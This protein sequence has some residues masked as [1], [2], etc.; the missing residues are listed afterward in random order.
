[1]LS[2]EENRLLNIEEMKQGNVALISR[3]RIA[4]I[5]LTLRCNMNCIMCFTQKMQKIDMADG[6]FRNA[7]QLFSTLEEARW[8]DAG[9]LFASHSC[10]EY[11]KII[12]GLRIPKSYLS[13]NLKD[14]DKYIDYLVGGGFT[15]LSVSIDAATGATYEAIRRGGK[16]DKLQ[17]NLDLLVSSKK[18]G[19]TEL[20][21]LT[22]VFIAMRR[23]MH[24][25]PAFVDLARR[26]EAREIHVLKLLPNPACL[27]LSETI[28]LEEL[29]PFYKE[30]FARAKEYGIRLSHIAYT[31]D[32][33]LQTD[34]K[35]ESEV[36]I[37]EDPALSSRESH[38]GFKGFPYCQSPWT[39]ILIDVEG[40][41]RPCCYNP[42][43]LGSLKEHS[44]LDIWNNEKYQDF[45]RKMLN[46]DFYECH[47]C[48]WQHK[49]FHYLSPE[50]KGT[51]APVNKRL[52]AMER[53][54]ELKKDIYHHPPFS[55]LKI[56]LDPLAFRMN[57]EWDGGILLPDPHQTIASAA[58]FDEQKKSLHH[59]LETI[60]NK[61][62]GPP[63]PDVSRKRPVK[64]FL[65]RVVYRLVRPIIEPE[66]QWHKD[67][68]IDS[69][70]RFEELSERDKNVVSYIDMIRTFLEN[71]KNFNA[72][73]VQY[74]NQFSERFF[75]RVER[76]KDLNMESLHAFRQTNERIDSLLRDNALLLQMMTHLD[77]KIT[78]PDNSGMP[79]PTRLD[80]IFYG[81]T[82]GI[83]G[84]DKEIPAASD[85]LL[86]LTVSNNSLKIWQ[87]NSV[88]AVGITVF[89]CDD[90]NFPLWTG[91]EKTTWLD[92]PLHPGETKKFD[93][94][95]SVPAKA[96]KYTLTA[97]LVA[98]NGD[99]FIDRGTGFEH[100]TFEVSAHDG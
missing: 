40:N 42:K 91:E 86:T 59:Q 35:A 24:E 15:H 14:A 36:V 64:N 11:L 21:Y 100:S 31:D 84:P 49:V 60:R 44:V 48:S 52:Q 71:Q 7:T 8:N 67:M 10:E 46:H 6:I 95:V 22:L 88:Y 26:Y 38:F 83:N 62:S 76:Q 51:F 87:P 29:R 68:A 4:S 20:P 13:T 78:G 43:V 1:M 90:R 16:F 93:I 94:T 17:K 73:L 81:A 66:F 72:L 27:E 53:A 79:F 39:E 37:E 28:E 77:E 55:D 5:G 18:R 96:G 70:Q 32:E 47:H 75:E 82:V 69:F 23:N 45:R 85:L 74:L 54:W 92:K 98:S 63:Q 65:K 25:L 12:D 50:E 58:N 80:D 89:W 34:R 61:V 99:K 97:T 57:K 41:V 9:E 2:R 19:N 56:A 33:L 30:A 3:P